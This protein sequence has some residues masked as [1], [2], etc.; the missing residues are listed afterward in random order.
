MKSYLDIVRNIIENGIPKQPTR[1]VDGKA[2]KVTN[3]TIGTFCEIFRH[4]MSDGFPLLTCRK[5]PIKS[6]LV[7]LEGFL[8][9]ITDKNWF[10]ERGCHYWDYWCNIESAKDFY[11]KNYTE[12]YEEYLKSNDFLHA[13]I[14]SQAP[15]PFESVQKYIQQSVADLGP[16]GYSWQ[17]RKF[18]EQFGPVEDGEYPNGINDGFDQLKNIV[19]TLKKNPYDRRMVCSG[20]N[21]NQL[22]LMALPPCHVLWNVVVYD[23][24]LNLTWF[25]RSNDILIGNP[26]NIASYATLLL[27]LAK[28]AKLEPGELVGIF[29]DAHIYNN[30][31]ENGKLLIQREPRKLPQLEI[32]CDDIFEWDHTQVKLSNYD[33]LPSMKFELTI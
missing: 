18:G 6:I 24:K 3:G 20:W 5:M 14:D 2:V 33:P 26:S 10:I 32:L 12:P 28:T 9:G 19:D 25:Q 30:Q 1:M 7:E 31:I 21:P 29:S 16:L 15:L 8:K 17:W 11:R 22:H 23:N 4:N 13:N 27:L